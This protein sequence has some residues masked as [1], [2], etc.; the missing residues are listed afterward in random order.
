[1]GRD[2]VSS[3]QRSGNAKPAF[4]A[5][6]ARLAAKGGRQHRQVVDMLTSAR[7]IGT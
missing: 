7:S 1:M 3:L 2:P 4:A 6:L 5:R